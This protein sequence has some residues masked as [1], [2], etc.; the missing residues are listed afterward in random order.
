MFSASR[1]EMETETRRSEV[2]AW[3]RAGASGAGGRG[4]QREGRIHVTLRQ[5]GD[6]RAP[7][8]DPAISRLGSARAGH[9]AALAPFARCYTAYT[10]ITPWDLRART[11][12]LE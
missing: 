1:L 12:Y 3:S 8:A 4:P 11:I 6:G 10:H 2:A 7:V 5:R 9:A